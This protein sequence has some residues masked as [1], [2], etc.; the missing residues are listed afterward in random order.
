[1]TNEQEIRIK[2]LEIAARSLPSTTRI[3][4]EQ[5][6]EDLVKYAGLIERYILEAGQDQKKP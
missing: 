3:V 6:V 5:R 4:F 1:M 2:S